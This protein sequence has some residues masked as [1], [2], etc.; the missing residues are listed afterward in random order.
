VKIVC[1]LILLAAMR[2]DSQWEPTFRGPAL[3]MAN[4][5]VFSTGL[6]TARSHS[7]V[8]QAKRG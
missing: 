2:G 5:V 4:D 3:R 7:R 1:A 6:N 8:C